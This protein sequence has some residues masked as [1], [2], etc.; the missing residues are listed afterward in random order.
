MRFFSFTL[1]VSPGANDTPLTMARRCSPANISPP[2]F[3]A[4]GN[5]AGI[6]VNVRDVLFTGAASALESVSSVAVVPFFTQFRI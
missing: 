2:N 1:F 5:G 3:N 6:F 4:A